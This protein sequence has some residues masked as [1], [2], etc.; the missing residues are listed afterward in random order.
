M[1]SERTLMCVLLFCY[2]MFMLEYTGN[3]IYCDLI[4]PRK[5]DIHVI[6]ETDNVLAYYHTKP[7]WPVHIVITPKKHIPSLLELDDSSV[8]ELLAVV[9]DVAGS[10]KEREGACRVMTNL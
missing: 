10:V 6:K 9:K 3:D 5:L 4:I 7:H 2:A 8:S 1:I